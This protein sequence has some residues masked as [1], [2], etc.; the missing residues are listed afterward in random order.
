MP[1]GR[2]G[3]VP[4][5][6]RFGKARQ[7]SFRDFMTAKFRL[8]RAKPAHQAALARSSAKAQFWRKNDQGKRH[9]PAAEKPGANRPGRRL[10]P[11]CSSVTRSMPAPDLA[12]R[13]DRLTRLRAAISENETRFE[14]AISADFGHRSTTETADRRNPAGARRDQA[15]RQAPEEMDGAAA[16]FDRAAVHAGQKPPDPAAGRRRRHH[17]A[18]ELSAAADAGAGGGGARRRQSRDDQA[19]RAG[20]AVFRAAAGK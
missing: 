2:E 6:T 18:V 17:R 5:R 20:A 7:R 12:E 3:Y 4:T 16:D 14:Q 8:Y 9:G 15:R 1:L 11:P 13:L 10:S 19:E